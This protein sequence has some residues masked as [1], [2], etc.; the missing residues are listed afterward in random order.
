MRGLFIT[1][2][3]TDV[4]KTWMTASIASQLLARNEHKIGL[5]K[6]ACSGSV[7]NE[8]GRLYWPDLEHLYIALRE[9]FPRDRIC[10]QTFEAPLAPPVAAAAEEKQIDSELLRTGIDWWRERVDMLLV[11]GVGGWYCPL[12][13]DEMV[14]DFATELAFPV[15]IVARLGLGTINHTLLT[16]DAVR[17][18][19]LTVAGVIL[20]EPVALEGDAS[21]E[22][23]AEQ[24]E[25]WGKTSVL[26]IS[27][28]D[29]HYQPRQT[30]ETDW[31]GL[32][33]ESSRT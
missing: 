8:E 30:E 22:S 6:P 29:Q 9:Q 27:R 16:L 23:N 3:D 7:R 2:T 28:H 14:A 17:S 25:R 33:V 31:F 4:G 26:G 21:V 18:R 12:S 24:I 10:P 19:G 15:V 11:E 20:N 13:E 5:Y 32:S 1:G